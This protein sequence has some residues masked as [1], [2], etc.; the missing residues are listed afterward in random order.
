MKVRLM[1][2]L[3]REV[4]L[5]HD[6]I[7]DIFRFV[8]LV[9]PLQPDL[10]EQYASEVK[11]VEEAQQVPRIG[12][13]EQMAE[14]RGEARGALLALREAVWRRCNC[15]SRG[16]FPELVSGCRGSTTWAL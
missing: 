2:Q 14:A 13:F 3:Q 10:A 1:R 8:D 9:M 4:R 7:E 15:G 6:E 11:K 16:S 12:Q 5:S